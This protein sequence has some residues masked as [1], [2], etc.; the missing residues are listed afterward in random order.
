MS[1]SNETILQVWEKGEPVTGCLPEF[2]RVD[3]HGYFISRHEYGNRDSQ[4]GWEI[5]HIVPHAMGGSSDVWN[6]RPL[7][8][9]TNAARQPGST[10]FQAGSWNRRRPAGSGTWDAIPD[11]QPPAWLG[12]SPN[13][14]GKGRA[15]DIP[16]EMPWPGGPRDTPGPPASMFSGAGYGASKK[17][18]SPWDRESEKSQSKADDQLGIVLAQLLG[19][20]T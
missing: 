18:G 17:S 11:H 3:D 1:F 8:W 20:D 13:P 5:D 2:I 19:F 15:S 6:L 4:F 12:S 10:L 9:R 16:P 7:H 14:W